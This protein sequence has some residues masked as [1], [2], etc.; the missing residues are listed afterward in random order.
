MNTRN[1]ILIIIL[2]LIC[3]SLF[4]GEPPGRHGNVPGKKGYRV[5]ENM[6]YFNKRDLSARKRKL[7]L[8]IGIG[9]GISILRYHGTDYIDPWIMQEVNEIHAHPCFSTNLRI[10]YAPSDKFYICCNA[11]SNWFS[12]AP[13]SESDDEEMY[14]GGGVGFGVTFFPFRRLG[15]LYINSLF[16]YSNLFRASNR[17]KNHFG[18]ILSLGAGYMFYEHF[19]G[20][21]NLLFSSSEK[22]IYG[23]Y[24]E[25]PLIINFTVS[26]FL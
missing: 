25:N 6:T 22:Y 11:R 4:P 12:N 5:V 10:G 23:F 1:A 17:D 14:A 3:Q 24:M 7:I 13:V 19:G 16:G 9:G 2:C 15:N 21:L 26:Y 18:T 20:E 8:G